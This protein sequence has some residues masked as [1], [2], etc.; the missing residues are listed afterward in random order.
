M[1]IKAKTVR[2]Y[3]E[4]LP[5]E[6]RAAIEAV[7]KVIL[8]NLPKGYEETTQH[9]MITYH[10]PLKLY[11]AGYLNKKDVPLPYAGLASQKNHMAVY[12]INIYTDQDSKEWF[13]N[14]YKASG[15]RMDVGKS[16]IRF[17]KLDDLPLDVIGKAIART[18]VKKF[19]EIYEKSRAR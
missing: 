19:I 17:R 8:K 18:P 16:C 7:R 15:K 14:A 6:R 9:G 10:V 12:L 1:L 4:K 11:P 13:H 3:L 5:A 2:E